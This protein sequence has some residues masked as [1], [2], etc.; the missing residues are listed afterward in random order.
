V[1]IDLEVAIVCVAFHEVSPH[2]GRLE[3][4]TCPFLVMVEKAVVAAQTGYGEG[5]ARAERHSS[6]EA[7]GEGGW[8]PHGVF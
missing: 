5:E 3:D 7:M 4:S 2:D 6:D 8:K 1:T